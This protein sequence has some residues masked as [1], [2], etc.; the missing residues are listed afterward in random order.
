MIGRYAVAML[1]FGTFARV[2]KEV[3][4]DVLAARD[5][6]PAARGVGPAEILA[7]WPGIHALLAYRVAHALHEAGV[8]LLPRAD[9][10]AHARA[11]RHRDPPRGAASAR[12]CSS[13]T[14]R[15]S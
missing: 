4:R 3:R 8:P 10:D 2:A 7:T 11:H 13:T 9:L 1:G 6:D 5:R 12:A 14:A 15:A